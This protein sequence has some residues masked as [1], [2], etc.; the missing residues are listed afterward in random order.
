[1]KLVELVPSDAA[2]DTL[3]STLIQPG[4]CYIPAGQTEVG[5]HDAH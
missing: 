1:V 5:L 3:A 2:G 4:G